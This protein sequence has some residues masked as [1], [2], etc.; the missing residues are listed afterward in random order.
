MA[1]SFPVGLVARSVNS[2][3]AV[4]LVPEFHVNENC[5]HVPTPAAV[6]PEAS[7]TPSMIGWITALLIRKIERECIRRIWRHG[8]TGLGA[9]DLHATGIVGRGSSRIVE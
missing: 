9:P 1:K 3:F 8:D 6:T 5:C 2:K 7:A 4:V